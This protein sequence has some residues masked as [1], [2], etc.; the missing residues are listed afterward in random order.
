[1]DGEWKWKVEG[2]KEREDESEGL[3]RLTGRLG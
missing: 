3:S 2:Q 1:M